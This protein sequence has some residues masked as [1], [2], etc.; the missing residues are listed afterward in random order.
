MEIR[1]AL[2][3]FV[4]IWASLSLR[5]AGN[6]IVCR[7]V[8]MIHPSMTLPCGPAAITFEHFLEGQGFTSIVAR[9]GLS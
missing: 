1:L 9:C 3:K 5:W 4:K 8:S 6:A 2:T 7:T